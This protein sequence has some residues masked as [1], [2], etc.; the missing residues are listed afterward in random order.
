M[1]HLLIM[2]GKDINS[3]LLQWRQSNKLLIRLSVFLF[4]YLREGSTF[5]FSLHCHYIVRQLRRIYIQSSTSGSWC[6]TGQISWTR[7]DSNPR[8]PTETLCGLVTRS[9]SRGKESPTASAWDWEL[10][11]PWSP[12]KVKALYFCRRYDDQ[13]MTANKKTIKTGTFIVLFL[14]V[15]LFCFCWTFFSFLFFFL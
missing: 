6:T 11:S 1:E 13:I 12:N 15:C 4:F 9:F 8:P 7:F 2:P 3:P 5:N 14:F 10:S